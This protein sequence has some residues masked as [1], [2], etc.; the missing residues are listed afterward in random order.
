MKAD[1]INVLYVC[2]GNKKTGISPIAINQGESLKQAGVKLEY[3]PVVGKGVKGY[4]R[5]VFHL[6]KHLSKNKYD[7]MHASYSL[8]AIMSALTFTSIPKVASLMG[9]DLHM[10]RFWKSLIKLNTWFFWKEVLVK[11]NEMKSILNLKKA[12]VIPNGVDLNL[13]KPINK[14]EAQIKINFNPL[15]KHVIF[16][17][18]PSRPEKNWKLAEESVKLLKDENVELHAIYNTPNELIPYYL[19]AADCL[20][21]TSLREGSPNAIKEALACNCPIAA[22]D[23]GDVRERIDGVE[24]CYIC[25]FDPENVKEKL[26][27][28]LSSDRRINGSEKIKDID[29]S[30]IAD[31][32]ISVYSSV[33]KKNINYE[34][35][36]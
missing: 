31:K 33:L 2:S 15:K 10:N 34:S 11:S 9:S 7:L 32:I 17:S 24:G 8:T 18:D 1:N 13:F 26:Q 35:F 28:I 6:R 20:L 30:V 25:S 27:A 12:H 29:S 16:L 22:T 21:L 4:F 14:T 3:F 36:N 23:V 19:S 5:N